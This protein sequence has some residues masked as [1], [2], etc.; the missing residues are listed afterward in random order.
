MITFNIPTYSLISY[1][2][3]KKNNPHGVLVAVPSGNNGDF[4]IGFAQCRKTDKFSKQM[5]LKIAFGRAKNEHLESW[6]HAPR[7]IRK[8][9]PAFVKRCE[10]YYQIKV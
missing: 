5:G 7:N 1:Y 8:M 2:R 3:D 9:L 4:N 6:D 10:R